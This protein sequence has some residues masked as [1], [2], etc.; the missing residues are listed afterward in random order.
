[1][2]HIMREDPVTARLVAA[3]EDQVLRTYIE[4]GFYPEYAERLEVVKRAIF[5]CSSCLFRRR[6]P[7]AGAEIEAAVLVAVLDLESFVVSRLR[8][9][10]N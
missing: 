1:M 3:L 4:N 7:V 6:I 5:L 9:R 10:F 8:A 2:D